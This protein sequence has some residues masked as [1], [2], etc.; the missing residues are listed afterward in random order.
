MKRIYAVAGVVLLV[1]L[2]VGGSVGS[3]QYAG[4]DT[5]QKPLVLFESDTQNAIAATDAYVDRHIAALYEHPATVN[6][7]TSSARTAPGR[8]NATIALGETEQG[9]LGYAFTGEPRLYH[10][11]LERACSGGEWSVVEFEL[12]KGQPPEPGSSQSP[13]PSSPA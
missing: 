4:S 7:I 8:I 6:W 1:L 9:F 12:V 13:K 11:V 2:V 5:C 10:I 3:R